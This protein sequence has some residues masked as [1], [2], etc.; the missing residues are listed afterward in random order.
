[1]C[2]QGSRRASKENAIAVIQ[3][4]LLRTVQCLDCIWPGNWGLAKR[5]R[6]VRILEFSSKWMF[7]WNLVEDCSWYITYFRDLGP[8][9]HAEQRIK[10]WSLLWL[11]IRM[12]PTLQTQPEPLCCYLE[13]GQVCSWGIIKMHCL[14]ARSAWIFE[15]TR[16]AEYETEVSLD[17]ITKTYILLG[18][19]KETGWDLDAWDL[20]HVGSYHRTDVQYT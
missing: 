7:L 12:K 17:F 5:L 18:L 13:I 3:W 16:K 11:I 14:W 10:I 8:A 19:I 9:I 2:L 15:I 6:R 4:I 1:M 20:D